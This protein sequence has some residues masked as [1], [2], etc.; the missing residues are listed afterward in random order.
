MRVKSKYVKEGGGEKEWRDKERLKRR[1][2]IN[3]R[4]GNELSFSFPLLIYK[5]NTNKQTIVNKLS[6]SSSA[7]EQDYVSTS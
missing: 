2:E 5:I 1:G 3:K 4:V 6:S 7:R